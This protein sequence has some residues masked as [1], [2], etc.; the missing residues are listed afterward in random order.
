VSADV[1]IDGVP[2]LSGPAR[3]DLVYGIQ[4][5]TASYTILRSRLSEVSTVP[6]GV[7][8]RIGHPSVGVQEVKRLSLIDASPTGHPDVVS[9]RVADQRY[10]LNRRWHA[11]VYNWR[12]R[13]GV[14]RRLRQEGDRIEVS[15]IAD[16]VTFAPW[17]LKNGTTAWSAASVLDEVLSSVWSGDWIKEAT[18]NV[19]V[20]SLEIDAQ[21]DAALA[22][23]LSLYGSAEVFVRPSGQLVV[24]DRTA[25]RAHL[26][27]APLKP[28]Y[29]N[30]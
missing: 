23:I 7:T 21:G 9:V 26:G 8:V 29:V 5:A 4:P 18:T 3:W 28:I 1:T 2:A 30:F 22:Q 15:T 16:D 17:S 27:A 25:I 10:W 12:R 14:R 6:N 11:G 13:S 19:P 20:E 24:R